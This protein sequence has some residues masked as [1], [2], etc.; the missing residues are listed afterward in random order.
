MRG[1]SRHLTFPGE[2][3]LQKALVKLF[4]SIPGI[5]DIQLLQGPTE[6]GKD[7]VFKHTGPFGEVVPCACVVKNTSINGKV[8]S[9][10]S[11]YTVLQQA[12]QALLNDYID[13]SGATVRVH[14]VFII[15]SG[16][17]SPLAIASI[18]GELRERAGQIHFIGG[19]ELTR[20]FQLHWPDFLA[21]QAAALSRYM[22]ETSKV[23]SEP[24]E[25]LKIS[26]LYPEVE[27]G[28][29]RTL[30][31]VQTGFRITLRNY[32]VDRIIPLLPEATFY[33]KHRSAKDLN[34]VQLKLDLLNELTRHLS[35]W[36]YV[37]PDL[38]T[39]LRN[40]IKRTSDL[41]YQSW[42]QGDNEIREGDVDFRVPHYS[43][44]LARATKQLE[45]LIEISLESLRS[46]LA[47]AG[48]LAV[49]ESLDEISFTSDSLL[50]YT[51]AADCLQSFGPFGDSDEEL[52]PI[53]GEFHL[54]NSNL[55]R[56]RGLLL[57][58]GPVGFGKT[59]L[60]RW[61][62]LEDLR[63]RNSGEALQIP[64]YVKLSLLTGNLPQNAR[65]LL[66]T[67]LQ[68]ALLS[69]D[70]WRSVL[71]GT[72]PVRL[73]LDGLDEMASAQERG[74][75]IELAQQLANSNP[76]W[77]ILL[78]G[79]DYIRGPWLKGIPRIELLGFSEE[80]ARELAEFMLR[81]SRNSSASFLRQLEEHSNLLDLCRVP[82]L[83]MLMILVFRN[84]GELP[85]R[86]SALY[87]TFVALL[88]GGW[89]LAK[90]IQRDIRFG[91]E[92]K[93]AI[94][95][96][97]AW[98]THGARRRTFSSADFEDACLRAAPGVFAAQTGTQRSSLT[99]N[100]LSELMAD[101]LIKRS[102]L[103]LQF[104]HQSFQEFMAA[105]ELAHSPS[106]DKLTGVLNDYFNGGDWWREVLFFFLGLSPDPEMLADSLEAQWR[107]QGRQQ[108]EARL[109]RLL[110]ELKRIFP[111]V[112]G[113]RSA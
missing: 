48:E 95:T 13:S 11:A 92:V 62:A 29:I 112:V 55:R 88:C 83:T 45:G 14:R 69:E 26:K 23:L 27:I 19:E 24:S 85:S 4:A 1:N 108:S 80:N 77:Q 51:H 16:H 107:S 59:S 106:S 66:E 18:S 5:S 8:S 87:S 31:Y 37:P 81:G 10:G 103:N 47:N 84:T 42:I 36:S 67:G 68:T 113:E 93:L 12:R 75:I 43:S 17:I 50:A 65:K 64:I 86:R 98:E 60:C 90:G 52:D 49:T 57:V 39:R 78:T 94:L 58:T 7:I 40:C 76:D 56:L 53:L 100:L 9:R 105:R 22:A 63:A 41:L 32:S 20:L 61:G 89:D 70:D 102:K 25:L 99:A 3:L 91:R 101:S 21:D 72:I 35:E 54:T 104:S 73:Y 6:F 97:L 79:R 74:R 34:G 2:A 109:A 46:D 44:E 82:L 15:T 30:H 33:H 110:R 71:R 38:E 28:E 96:R 111:G